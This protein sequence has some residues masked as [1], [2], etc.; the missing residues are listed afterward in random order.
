MRSRLKVTRFRKRALANLGWV[1]AGIL[2]I[3]GCSQFANFGAT[4]RCEQ[5]V[6]DELKA[7]ATAKYSDITI[8]N[9]DS[10][11]F[12]I[13]GSVD[14]EN[15]FGALIRSSFECQSTNGHV[16]LMSID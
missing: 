4:Q 15:G 13:Y 2:P 8:E 6:S 10:S 11:T 12:N 14:A 16:K 3:S 1:L 5:L 7:P 9:L